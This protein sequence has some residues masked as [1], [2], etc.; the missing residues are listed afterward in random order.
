LPVLYG[1]VP[2]EKVVHGR[3]A[4]TGATLN[5]AIRSGENRASFVVQCSSPRDNDA[6]SKLKAR[7]ARPYSKTGG[8]NATRKNREAAACG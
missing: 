2:A 1:L 3:A 6:S 8:T 7:G 4:R 5:R